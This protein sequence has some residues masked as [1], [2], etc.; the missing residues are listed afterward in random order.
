MDCTGH[1]HFWG[2]ASC[3]G[4]LW[5][6]PICIPAGDGYSVSK[7]VA[8][9]SRPGL[10]SRSV[11]S[12]DLCLGAHACRETRVRNVNRAVSA[13]A[14]PIGQSSK[15]LRSR[16]LRAAIP[17]W[18]KNPMFPHDV[19]LRFLEETRNSHFDLSWIRF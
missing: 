10:S 5:R 14:A 8:L 9:C 15:R 11:P 1:R 19:L 6:L 13:V 7:L 3:E 12:Y 2:L 16:R 17:S 18:V 4:G